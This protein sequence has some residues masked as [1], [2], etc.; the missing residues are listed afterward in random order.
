MAPPILIGGLHVDRRL[1]DFIEKEVL[2]PPDGVESLGIDSQRF[3]NGFENAIRRLQPVCE[4]L[5]QKR[6]F[7]QRRID[8]YHRTKRNEAFDPLDYK[9]FL[10]K[11]GYLVDQGEDFQVQVQDV[12]PEIATMAGPQLVVPLSNP[13]F[14]LNAV[15]ARWGSLFDSLYGSDVIPQTGELQESSSY[16]PKRGQ[17]VIKRACDF[18]DATFPMRKG[19]YCSIK[20]VKLQH[21]S[22]GCILE[23]ILP[24]SE[25]T[26][27]EDPTL[28]AGYSGDIQP[29]QESRAG[30]FSILLRHNNLHVELI[31]D[32]LNAKAQSEHPAALKDVLLESALSTIQDCEDSVT[33]VDAEDKIL[34][35]RNWLGLCL[36]TL[37]CEMPNKKIRSMNP[38]REFSSP[39]GNSLVLPGRSLML[40]RNVGHHMFT[41]AVTHAVTDQQIP[42]GFL[43]AFV[44]SLIGL[45]DIKGLGQKKNSRKGTIYIVKPKQHGPEEVA[46]TN[47]LLGMVEQT[48]GLPR[49]TIK[50]GLMD[51][52][53]RTSLN[54]KACIREAHRRTI[55][56]NT[57]FLDRTGDEIHTSFELGAFDLKDNLKSGAWIEAY[58]KQNVQIGLQCGMFGRGQIG[59]GMWAEPDGMKAMVDSKIKHPKGGAS[60]AWV[61]SPKAATLHALH[62]HQVRV[63]EIQKELL[64]VCGEKSGQNESPFLDA[65]LQIQVVADRS[66]FTARAIQKELD[67]NVQGLLGYVVRWIDQGVGCSKVPNIDGVGLME[68]R[69]TLRISSQHVANWLRHGIVSEGQVFDTMRQMA[70]VVDHQNSKDPQYLPMEPHPFTSLAYQAA[71]DLVF[72]GARQP[73]GYTEYILHQKRREAKK[74]CNGDEGEE[75]GSS[76]PGESSRW[77]KM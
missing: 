73:N 23:F 2:T 8:H 39:T 59:K 48:L 66:A 49:Y 65:L 20:G 10:Y 18:L 61:P 69:A 55:F 53:R 50:L 35:Y 52:E 46:L 31:F 36:G 9:E 63:H 1:H 28:F 67:N 17:A 13:R 58:E 7:L 32:P 41:D 76:M 71:L 14:S 29:N 62:Y 45:Y 43:D 34:L 70:A 21:Q 40:I 11:I 60:T 57:G 25:I 24:S 75:E 42:E 19:S 72:R 16:N 27:L 38:D 3:W 22:N 33:A 44:T 6:E 12:D 64:K 5:L 51:E 30:G 54:L 26:E 37:T 15:N 4:S 68:D 56:I 77:C 47:E 74:R